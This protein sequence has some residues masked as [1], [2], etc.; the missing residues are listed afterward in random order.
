MTGNKVRMVVWFL[1]TSNSDFLEPS[2]IHP[3]LFP[4]FCHSPPTAS[5]IFLS[6]P[7]TLGSINWIDYFPSCHLPCY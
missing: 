4:F 6:S 7:H 5:L 2:K 1:L 3:H